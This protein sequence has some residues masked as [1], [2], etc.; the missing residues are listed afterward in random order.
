[1]QLFPQLVGLVLVAGEAW[2]NMGTEDKTG[3]R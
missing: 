3:L 1:M 2:V